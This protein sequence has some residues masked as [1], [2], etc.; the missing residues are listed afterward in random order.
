MKKLAF[1]L[2]MFLVGCS[3][4]GSEDPTIQLYYIKVTMNIFI[5]HR[6]TDTN[7]V[8]YTQSDDYILFEKSG[9]TRKDA[10]A[11]SMRY[12][13]NNYID[14]EIEVRPDPWNLTI[15]TKKT[16]KKIII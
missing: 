4:G 11:I 6:A 12:P 10:D 7:R 1:V 5:E 15:I 16:Y 3:D 2:V 14:E 9:L 13:A 8:L